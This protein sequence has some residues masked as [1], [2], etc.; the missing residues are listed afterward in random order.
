M[1]VYVCACVRACV[2]AC[3]HVYMCMLNFDNRH[4]FQ[5]SFLFAYIKV[6]FFYCGAFCFIPLVRAVTFSSL[7]VS[8]IGRFYKGDLNFDMTLYIVH[9][10]VSPWLSV[11][12]CYMETRT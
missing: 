9:C 1:C 2:H 5:A 11:T 4:I 12:P 8:C 7:C 3:L 6:F 10:T